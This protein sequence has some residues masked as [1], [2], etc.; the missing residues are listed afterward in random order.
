MKGFNRGQARGTSLENAFTAILPDAHVETV[1]GQHNR[2]D[3]RRNAFAPALQHY[4]GAC[5]AAERPSL[6]GGIVLDFVKAG[7]SGNRARLAKFFGIGSSR[8]SVG[9]KMLI[10]IGGW[11]EGTKHNVFFIW[12]RM[13]RAVRIDPN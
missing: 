1:G 12:G 5:S 7:N 6:L 9:A 4:D 11:R 13:G 3:Q 10:V 8:E 2:F